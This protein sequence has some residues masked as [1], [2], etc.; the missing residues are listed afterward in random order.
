DRGPLERSRRRNHRGA[1]VHRV[2]DGA[3]PL[4]RWGWPMAS[5]AADEHLPPVSG[6]E[7]SGSRASL[8]RLSWPHWLAVVVV[9]VGL[10]VTAGL[11][12][13]TKTLYDNNENRLLDLRVRDVASVLAVAQQSVKTP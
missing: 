11:V 12:V 9:I 10:L 1:S 5:A 6:M 13:L 7:K 3:G 2:R 8:A 4:G